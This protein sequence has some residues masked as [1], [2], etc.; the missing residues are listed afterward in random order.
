MLTTS[1]P[2]MSKTVNA[3]KDQGL[4]FKIIVSGAPVTQEF[5]DVIGANRYGENVPGAVE[6]VNRLYI[7]KKKQHSSPF[8][9]H[10]ASIGN[11]DRMLKQF[12]SGALYENWYTSV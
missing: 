1:M 9:N 6:Q 10:I 5:A 4:S 2:S 3:F 11:S 12:F 8:F 7:R